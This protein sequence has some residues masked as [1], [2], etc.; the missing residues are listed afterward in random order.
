MARCGAPGDFPGGIGGALPSPMT[1]THLS[2]PLGGIGRPVGPSGCHF[3]RHCP[4][5]QCAR[6][7]VGMRSGVCGSGSCGASGPMHAPKCMGCLPYYPRVASSSTNNIGGG[8]GAIAHRY[9]AAQ[10]RA[11]LA[12]GMRPGVCVWAALVHFERSK[13]QTEAA[14]VFYA[15]ALPLKRPGVGAVL[16][17]AP[18]DSKSMV[19]PFKAAESVINM[20]PSH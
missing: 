4:T 15:P 2:S 11:G 7:A 8:T 20:M 5:R 9:S 10:Q 18:N 12:A 3:K 13:A 19:L 14:F 17:K 1:H 16:Y 6:L